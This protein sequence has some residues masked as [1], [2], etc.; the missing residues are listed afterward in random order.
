MTSAPVHDRTGAKTTLFHS[1]LKAAETIATGYIIG[2]IL[3]RL[4]VRFAEEFHHVE[5]AFVN[6]EVD[7]PLFKV[8]CMRFPDFRFRV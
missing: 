2:I 3:P 8:R 5:A 6:V 4:R 7:I 1:F